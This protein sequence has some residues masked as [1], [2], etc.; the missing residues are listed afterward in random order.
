MKSSRSRCWARLMRSTLPTRG[1]LK[2]PLSLLGFLT[3]LLLVKLLLGILELIREAHQLKLA[4]SHLRLPRSELGVHLIHDPLVLSQRSLPGGDLL[5]RLGPRPPRDDGLELSIERL[6]PAEE[7][8]LGARLLE[9]VRETLL[10]HPHLLDEFVRRRI[11]ALDLSP[12]VEIRRRLELLLRGW[13]GRWGGVGRWGG[14]RK[15]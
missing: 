9:L 5:R 12:P 14:G 13:G 4:L 8:R 10:E 7:R 2:Q 15:C 6:L 3:L 11:R 1:S